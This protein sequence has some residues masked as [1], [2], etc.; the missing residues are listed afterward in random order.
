MA[1]KKS[2]K[3]RKIPRSKVLDK[4]PGEKKSS[5]SSD[6][7]NLI[8]IR[9]RS[10]FEKYLDDE[11]PVIVDFWAPWCG[12][13]KAFGPTFEKVSAEFEDRVHFLKINTEEQPQLSQELNIR[14]IPTI[15]VFHGDE[16]TDKS[17]GMM[18]ESA[19]IKMAK[20]AEDKAKGVT[21]GGKIKRFFGSEQEE[22]EEATE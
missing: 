11:K 20:R 13:C 14:S 4:K 8:N 16:I 12:P 1:K 7:A 9:S 5:G 6:S 18:N 2:T 17:M 22:A 3:K 15:L 19:L 10:Q 21:L